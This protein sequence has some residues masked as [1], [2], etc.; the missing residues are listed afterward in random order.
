MEGEGETTNHRQS[1]KAARGT[2]LSRDRKQNS[3]AYLKNLGKDCRSKESCVL[4]HDLHNERLV[5]ELLHND[6]DRQR[7]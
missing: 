3:D 2:G 7:T 1:A 4:D 6:R 5:N